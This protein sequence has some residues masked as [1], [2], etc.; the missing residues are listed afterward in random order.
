MKV[1]FVNPHYPIDPKT[2]LLHPP[3]CYGYL[4]NCLKKRGHEVV[5]VDLPFIGNKAESVLEVLSAFKPDMLGITCVAQSYCQALEIAKLTKERSPQTAICLGGP[6]V[7][8]IPEECLKRHPYI[9]YIILFD[10]ELSFCELLDAL[11]SKKPKL[12]LNTV[13]G[14]AW[15]SNGSI[16]INTPSLPSGSLDNFTPDRSIFDMKAYHKHDYETVIMTARGCPGHC[17]FCSTSK[18]GRRY[19]PHGIDYVMQQIHEVL[20]LGFSSVFFGDDTFV[21]NKIRVLKICEEI[22]KQGLD[23]KWTCNMRA[24]DAT[25]DVLDGMRRAGAY[26]VFVGFETIQPNALE[27][28]GKGVNANVLYNSARMIK[29]SGLELHTSFIIGAPGDTNESLEATMDFIRLINP[30]LATFNVI[31]PRPGTDLYHNPS[32]Y[33]VHLI[34]PYWYESNE[35]IQSP[36]CYT[37]NLTTEQIR[38]WVDRAYREFCSLDFR[39]Q[40][41]LQGMNE[42]IKHLS[43]CHQ[44]TSE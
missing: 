26:R 38:L 42:T 36:V 3:L 11:N 37:D 19:R 32:K 14:L 41:N 7:S 4:S 33:G 27:I 31:E 28:V 17:A 39:S 13:A 22:T 20:D 6:H 12:G 35:W 1:L 44:N 23:F 24:V 29:A 18:A 16:I 34:N 5:H 9:D 2:L 25:P 10:G 21:A 43:L 8:F 40:E 15:R 30:T